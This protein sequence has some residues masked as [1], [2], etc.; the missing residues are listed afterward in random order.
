MNY[1]LVSVIT[2][3]KMTKVIKKT[4]AKAVKNCRAK[5]KLFFIIIRKA[6]SSERFS[7][8]ADG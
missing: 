8:G 6:T 3:G 4:N 5:K 7:F 1:S 2:A